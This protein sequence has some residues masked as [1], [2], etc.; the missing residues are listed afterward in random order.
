MKKLIGCAPTE[1]EE[2]RLNGEV[3]SESQTCLETKAKYDCC[4]C[5]GK[6]TFLNIYDFSFI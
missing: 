4:I 5:L 1:S 2:K 6:F 3:K